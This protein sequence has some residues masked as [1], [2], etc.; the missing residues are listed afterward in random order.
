[1]LAF[2]SGKFSDFGVLARLLMA[3]GVADCVQG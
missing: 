1:M 2:F 3:F